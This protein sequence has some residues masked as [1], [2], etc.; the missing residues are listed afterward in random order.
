ML[1]KISIILL[2]LP[3]VS[4][5]GRNEGYP[6]RLLMRSA[7]VSAPAM[8][9]AVPPPSEGNQ[10]FSYSHTL[11]LVMGHDAVKTRYDRARERCLHDAA[12]QCKL[13]TANEADNSGFASA[14]IEVALPH[15]KVA[16]FEDALLKPLKEDKNGVDIATRSTQAQSVEDEASDTNKKVA[17]LTKYRDGLAQLAKRPNLSVDDFIKVQQELSQTEANL[18][19]AL[20]QKRDIDGRIA[21]ESLTVDLTQRAE[22]ETASPLGQV[23]RESGD[24]FMDSTANVLRFIIQI[25]PGLPIAAMLFFLLRWLFRIARRRPVVA[26]SKESNG[27]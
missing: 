11:S 9:I 13:V 5:C 21:R 25:V 19:E 27:G 14:H 26:K 17:Q 15:D 23:W 7:S 12:L 22:I 20:A 4:G 10:I 2:A 18:D 16:A 1:R 24:L 6:E 3:L 8:D